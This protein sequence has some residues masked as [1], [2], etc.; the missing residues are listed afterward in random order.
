MIARNLRA[1]TSWSCIDIHEDIFRFNGH[2]P[3]S[4]KRTY[5]TSTKL[6][7]FAGE[8]ATGGDDVN[9]HAH[10]FSNRKVPAAPHPPQMQTPPRCHLRSSVLARAEAG[11]CE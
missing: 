9:P 11:C 6:L 2:S 5:R 8:T 7:N 1:S 10:G 3:T 4:Q